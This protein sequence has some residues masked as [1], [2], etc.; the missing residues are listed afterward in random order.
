MGPQTSEQ[1]SAEPA[2]S[3]SSPPSRG[4]AATRS[5]VWRIL[6]SY[7]LVIAFLVLIGVFSALRP[8]TFATTLNF[9][10]ILT[11]NASLTLLALGV[12]LP[13]IAQRFDLT[14]GYMATLSSLLAVGF[15]S[16]HSWSPWAAIALTLGICAVVGLINGVLI[17]YA[18]LN[19][20]VVTLGMGSI[21]FGVAELYSHGTTIFSNISPQFIKLGQ[22]NLIGIPL[23]FIYAAVASIAIWYLLSFRPNGRRLYAIGGSEEAARLMGVRV[24]RLILAAFVASAMLSGAGGIVEAGRVGS[25]NP[26]DLQYTLLPA[27]T[28][29]FLGATVFRPGQYNVWGTV[30]SIYLVGVG[31]TGMFI[32]GAPSFYSQVFDGAVLL[33]AIGLAELTR[34][35]F[36]Q[37]GE[38]HRGPHRE[39][40]MVATEQEVSTDESR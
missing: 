8:S 39:G 9:K 27:F 14:P 37:L 18:K 19:S 15:Q 28:A 33:V 13:L 30:L 29:A 24:E 11:E 22:K 40:W 25:A 10:A 2:T 38:A 36:A 26:T 3:G 7:G 5:W 12:T 20:L 6:Y 23:P 34:R 17:A 4:A 31:T 16:F 1:L 35:K 21:L 32:L